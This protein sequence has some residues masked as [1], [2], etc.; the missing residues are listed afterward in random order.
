MAEVNNVKWLEVALFWELF[1]TE[2]SGL[3]DAGV[4]LSDGVGGY[5]YPSNATLRYIR[6][7]E[8]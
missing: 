8:V 3:P 2:A 4:R 5:T 7:A 6:V 1:D